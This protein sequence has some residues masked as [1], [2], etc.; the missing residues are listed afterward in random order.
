MKG[1]LF[2]SKVFQIC[3]GA[4]IF[5]VELECV[6]YETSLSSIYCLQDSNFF[7]MASIIWNFF[8]LG[9]LIHTILHLQYIEIKWC[10]VTG[11]Q[12]KNFFLFFQTIQFTVLWILFFSIVLGNSAVLAALFLN[13]TRKSRMNFFIMQL[14]FAGKNNLDFKTFDNLIIDMRGQ[15][16]RT[17]FFFK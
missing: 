17:N 12:N 16:T 11:N 5:A 15:S 1:K 14:A 10:F 6:C 4:C 2:I 3:C 7:N 13:N 8:Y 9:S